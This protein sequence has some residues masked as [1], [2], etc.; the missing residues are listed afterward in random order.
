MAI[1]G[2]MNEACVTESL[3]DSYLPKYF[4]SFAKLYQCISGISVLFKR[5][6][7]LLRE[8]QVV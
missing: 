1:V 2:E 8:L 6:R 3:Q 7:A 4:I 5:H